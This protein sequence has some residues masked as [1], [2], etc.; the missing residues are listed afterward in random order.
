MSSP[1]ARLLPVWPAFLALFAAVLVPAAAFL[2][3]LIQ[4]IVG[5]WLLPVGG[6]AAA[7][8]VS[9]RSDSKVRARLSPSDCRCAAIECGRT[10][11]SAGADA[12]ANGGARFRSSRACSLTSSKPA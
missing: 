9:R 2:T 6:G 10:G 3:F 7:A 5:R 8:W 12:W 11:T 4:P 1:F